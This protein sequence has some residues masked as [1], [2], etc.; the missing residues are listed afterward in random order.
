[1]PRAS[2]TRSTFHLHSRTYRMHSALQ[3]K[4]FSNSYA[5]RVEF[6]LKCSKQPPRFNRSIGCD[7]VNLELSPGTRKTSLRKHVQQYAS[8]ILGFRVALFLCERSQ[9]VLAAVNWLTMLGR[10]LKWKE[11][12]ALPHYPHESPITLKFN[13]IKS[14]FLLLLTSSFI[15]N[16]SAWEITWIFVCSGSLYI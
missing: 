15:Q 3:L 9:S 8:S 6:N 4:N 5:Q 2:H 10:Y 12:H 14:I 13:I 1:M 7:I 11:G 16:Y